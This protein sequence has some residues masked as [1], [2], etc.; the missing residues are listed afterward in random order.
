[1]SSSLR[2]RHSSSS[3]RSLLPEYLSNRIWSPTFT[4]STL[5][6]DG[7]NDSPLGFFLRGIRHIDPA[8]RPLQSP[9]CRSRIRGRPRVESLWPRYSFPS[10]LCHNANLLVCKLTRKMSTIW[11][12]FALDDRGLTTPTRAES[13]ILRSWARDSPVFG[14]V[15]RDRR[16]NFWPP[17]RSGSGDDTGRSSGYSRP[18]GGKEEENRIQARKRSKSFIS[19]FM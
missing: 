10:P 18:F 7:L 17:E 6:A 9:Q 8:G 5:L 12:G 1:M 4:F 16:K 11:N 3:I 19:F 13:L 15:K 2:M 14:R